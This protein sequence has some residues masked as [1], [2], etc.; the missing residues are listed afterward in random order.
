MDIKICMEHGN[1]DYWDYIHSCFKAR[2]HALAD[3]ACANQTAV[4][5]A[6]MSSSF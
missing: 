4:L 3:D 2:L 6:T 5:D 1:Y